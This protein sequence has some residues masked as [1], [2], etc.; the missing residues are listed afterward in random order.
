MRRTLPV[1]LLSSLLLLGCSDDDTPQPDG[2]VGGDVSVSHDGTSGGDGPMLSDGTMPIAP[3]DIDTC[4]EACGYVGVCIG[5]T[6]E[7]FGSDLT[8]CTTGCGEAPA[9]DIEAVYSCL[10][11]TT[12]DDQNAIIACAPAGE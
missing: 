5:W 10:R 7:E 11:A 8:S 12:C 1:I 2:N 9:V 4:D 6:G 3:G